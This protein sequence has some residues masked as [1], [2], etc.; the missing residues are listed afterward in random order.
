MVVKRA[1]SGKLPALEW[2]RIWNQT[3]IVQ[4]GK[5]LEFKFKT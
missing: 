3:P 5:I 4:W 1:Q 2:Y